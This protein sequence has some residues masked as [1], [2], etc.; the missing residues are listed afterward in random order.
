MKKYGLILAA[1]LIGLIGGSRLLKA[2]ESPFPDWFYNWLRDSSY[3]QDERRGLG[4]QRLAHGRY[5]FTADGGGTIGTAIPIG[6]TLPAN[7]VVSRVYY[8][9]TTAFTSAATGH[10]GTNFMSLGCG[11]GPEFKASTD[12]LGGSATGFVEGIQTG[13]A[14]TMTA[15]ATSCQ[16]AL[17]VQSHSIAA[18]DVDFYINYEIFQ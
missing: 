11:T 9:V 4:I 3:S 18:G 7:A 6:V 16:V 2:A 13:S 12:R 1:L 8:Y 15:S 14:A 17:S 10:G 5:N